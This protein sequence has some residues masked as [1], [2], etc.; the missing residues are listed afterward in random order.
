MI[1][2]STRLS[3]SKICLNRISVRPSF[4]S[5]DKDAGAGSSGC[6]L[7]VRLAARARAVRL[8]SRLTVQLT[9]GAWLAIWLAARARAI[10]LTVQSMTGVRL[11]VRP[12]G[13]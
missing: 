12:A 11:A 13:G 9:A 1:I 2:V 6:Q 7:A 5:S 4:A 10:R 3:R 8:G